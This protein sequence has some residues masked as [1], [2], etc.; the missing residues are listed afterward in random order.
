M[1]AENKMEVM[2]VGKLIFEMSLPPLFSMFLQYS[3]NLLDSAFVARLSENA[4]TAVSLSFPIT[5]LMNAVSIWIGVGINVL[6]AGHL[7]KREQE[8]ANKTVTLGLILS[9]LVGIILNITV[10]LIISPYFKSFTENN[11]IYTLCMEYMGVCSF[12]QIP[13]MV[14]IVIQKMIQATGNMIEP[15]LFQLMGVITNFIFDPLLI[16]GIDFFPAMGI[17]GAATATVLGYSVS[18]VLAFIMFLKAKHKIALKTVR[19]RFEWSIVQKIIILGLPSFIMNALNA[20]TV[21][22]VNLFLVAY[23]DTSIAFLGA[24]FKIQQLII[25]TINGL[26]QGCLPIMRFNYGAGNLKRL[27]SVFRYSTILVTSLMMFGTLIIMLFPTQILSLFMASEKMRSYG[28][29]AMRIMATGYLFCG[30]ST[31]ISTYMQ[32]IERVLPSIM[33]QIFRQMFFLIPIMWILEKALLINGIWIAFP[34]TELLTFVAAVI[35][36][37]RLRFQNN[38]KDIVGGK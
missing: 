10:L 31:M 36:F 24:Y 20:F 17:K 34:V 27:Q 6:I 18:M 19:F 30:L 33:I 13:N 8:E 23:S 37:M 32:A 7:G 38:N 26:I 21:T 9:F 35:L 1:M 16:F 5:T 29:M 12:M 3:Y 28:I 15:M 4:L 2:P 22:I 11:D 14:H 25:M